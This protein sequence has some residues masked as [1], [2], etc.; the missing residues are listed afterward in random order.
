MINFLNAD[1][2]VEMKNT[3]SEK[4]HLIITD[5]PYMKYTSRSQTEGEHAISGVFSPTDFD[6]FAMNIFRLLKVSRHAYVF[7]QFVDQ[8]KRDI[9]GMTLHA[10]KKAGFVHNQ[11]L[12]WTKR[13]IGM[14]T[15]WRAQLEPILV[16]TKPNVNQGVSAYREFA[17]SHSNLLK[18]F[19]SVPAERM[20]HPT[21]KPVELGVFLIRQSTDE[22]ELVLDPFAG[23][24][25]FLLAAGQIKRN[26]VGYEILPE[27]WKKG[28]YLMKHF[29]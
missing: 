6:R 17:K 29:V 3:P 18:D 26:V 28:L 19:P 16:L 5:P 12:I 21:Q 2:W 14:G 11:T 8:D 23:V 4:Y 13:N 15:G 20:V 7:T 1:A 25:T 22:G 9:Y 27:F 24:G 10:L